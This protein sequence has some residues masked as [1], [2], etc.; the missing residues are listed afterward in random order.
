MS[1]NPQERKEGLSKRHWKFLI[2]EN[3]IVPMIAN[4]LINSGIT[5]FV[6]VSEK[7]DPIESLEVQMDLFATAFLLSFI[8]LLLTYLVTKKSIN[9]EKLPKLKAGYVSKVDIMPSNILV[10]AIVLGMI[11]V[12]FMATPVVLMLNWSNATQIE[13]MDYVYFKGIWAGLTAVLISPF[14]AWWA[15]VNYSK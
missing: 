14:A 5:Y 6:F 2:I 4:I 9:K 12:A 13:P 1:T 8:T 7:K 10:R 3:A 15:L 11:G